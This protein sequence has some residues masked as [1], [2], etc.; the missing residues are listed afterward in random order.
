MAMDVKPEDCDEFTQHTYSLTVQRVSHIRS[1]Y[2]IERELDRYYLRLKRKLHCQMHLRDDKDIISF[3][4]NKALGSLNNESKS[5]QV[6]YVLEDSAKV[7]LRVPSASNSTL[8]FKLLPQPSETLINSEDIMAI[9]EEKGDFDSMFR[10]LYQNQGLGDGGSVGVDF[11]K[12]SCSDD[13][14]EDEGEPT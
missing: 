8:K 9:G 14:G 3:Q 7:S 11:D 5:T 4:V 1:L 13:E 6:K 10:S 2:G 12:I